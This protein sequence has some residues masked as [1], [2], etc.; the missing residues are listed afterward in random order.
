[1]A[2]FG[3]CCCASG[4]ELSW[5]Q[6]LLFDRHRHEYG[7]AHT[8]EPAWAHAALWSEGEAEQPPTEWSGMAEDDYDPTRPEFVR[9]ASAEE[10]ARESR[11][12][13]GRQLASLEGM[14][15]RRARERRRE[16]PP[17]AVLEHY[18]AVLEDM[19]RHTSAAAEE[20]APAPAPEQ[21]SDD[22][23]VVVLPPMLMPRT[24]SRRQP[25]AFAVLSDVP[26]A[27]SSC[28]DRKSSVSSLVTVA[29]TASTGWDGSP[30]SGRKL[31]PSSFVSWARGESD[32]AADE[33]GVA[34]S[35]AP[36]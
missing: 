3:G 7:H 28:G 13:L 8:A 31:A 20:E 4:D 19:R 17:E 10:V 5:A 34:Q 15:A 24:L 22:E 33:G 9:Y 29:S 36:W 2:M 21:E 12:L 27:R 26:E 25:G 11:A 18:E 23:D 30:K 35:W 16:D 6:T 14:V 32:D 1:M